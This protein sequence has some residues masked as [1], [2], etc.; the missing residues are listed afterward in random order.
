MQFQA[1]LSHS[2][3]MPQDPEPISYQW[4]WKPAG[5]EQE[6]GWGVAAVW[7]RVVP[8]HYITNFQCSKVK[9]RKLCW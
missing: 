4:Q 5:D 9:W 2:L 8:Q 3:S 7:H 1:N 6:G